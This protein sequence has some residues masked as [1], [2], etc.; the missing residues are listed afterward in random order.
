MSYIKLGLMCIIALVLFELDRNIV[1][2]II[3]T[4]ASTHKSMKTVF[5]QLMFDMFFLLH[6]APLAYLSHIFR[7][8]L[9]V[10]AILQVYMILRDSH[11]TLGFHLI[12]ARQASLTSYQLDAACIFTCAGGIPSESSSYQDL[13]R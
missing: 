13:G 10:L 3:S 11:R 2:S 5:D 7:G 12:K 8:N 6:I 1:I 9:Q 4:K